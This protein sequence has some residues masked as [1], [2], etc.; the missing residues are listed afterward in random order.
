MKPLI[1]CTTRA[2]RLRHPDFSERISFRGSLPFGNHAHRLRTVP[3]CCG[4]EPLATY[5]SCCAT[6]PREYP[7]ALSLFVATVT[8][9]RRQKKPT[10]RNTPRYS[11]TSAYSRT[12]FPA[13]LGCPFS[14]RPTM[15]FEVGPLI[16]TLQ[17]GAL[18]QEQRGKGTW[19]LET[20]P[21]KVSTLSHVIAA[22]R[23][24]FSAYCLVVN[25]ARDRC[26]GF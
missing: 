14:S 25:S 12:G 23:P 6:A 4:R 8:N 22:V 19:E 7:S 9:V 16:P 1:H 5:A 20:G 13:R 3:A 17:T 11:T 15:S 10:W 2:A 18:Y 24:H 26:A 21:A